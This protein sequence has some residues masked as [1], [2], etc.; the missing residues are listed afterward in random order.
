LININDL[1]SEIQKELKDYSNKVFIQNQNALDETEKVLI[2]NLKQ[3]SPAN[4]GLFKKS[5]KSKGRKYKNKRYVGNTKTVGNGIPLVNI[6][7]Y[8]PTKGKP[9]V[10]KTFEASIPAMVSKFTETIKK[11][12]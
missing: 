12:V 2:N 7:E 11:G 4:T 5:W 8:S 6:L 9:F 3:N 1:A 10:Q